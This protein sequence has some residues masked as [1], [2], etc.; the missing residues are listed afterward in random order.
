MIRMQGPRDYLKDSGHCYDVLWILN[1][2]VEIMNIYIF[3]KIIH[4]IYEFGSRI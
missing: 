2:S 4:Y 3:L 1:T